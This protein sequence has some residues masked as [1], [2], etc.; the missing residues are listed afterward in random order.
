MFVM[1]VL[2]WL[3]LFAVR[4]PSITS[5][6][7]PADREILRSDPHKVRYLFLSFLLAMFE[8]LAVDDLES[9]TYSGL[10]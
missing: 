3:T 1:V 5:P 9:L 4:A 6:R 8:Q 10:Y 7:V 2:T